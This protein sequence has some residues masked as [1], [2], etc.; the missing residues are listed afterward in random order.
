MRIAIDARY[1]HDQ[2]PGIGRYTYN[3]IGG[4]AQAAEA[5][6]IVVVHNS[7]LPSSRFDVAA[8][9]ELPRVEMAKTDVPLLSPSE[10]WR[11]PLLAR[12]LRLDVWHTPYYVAPYVLPCPL[13]V[14]IHD[15]IS[16]RYPQYLPSLGARL[17]YQATMRL[18][19]QAARRV[20]TVSQASRADLQHFFGLS[21]NKVDV[22]QE[23]AHSSYGPQPAD[24]ISNVLRRL[25]LRQPYALYLGMNKP[26]KNVARLVEAWR[27]ALAYPDISGAQT[28]DC[29]AGVQLVMAGRDDP[30]Y[31]QA[32]MMVEQTGIGDCVRFLGDVAEQDMPA[33]Y[34]GAEV[35]VFPSL[36]EGF[37]L[38]P[39]E[40]MACGAPVIC[41]TTPALLETVGDAAITVDALDAGALAEAL[42]RVLSQPELRQE[43]S[44]RSLA[45]AGRFNWLRTAHE[46]LDV[47]HRAS[48]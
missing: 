24:V 26:H 17:A 44:K 30:R 35:F 13:V 11:L 27:L 41:S 12:R 20:I 40:A 34:S 28:A 9:A 22:V 36:Y 5:D 32:Q 23:A 8:L 43:M 15:A 42:L 10:Q 7:A 19:I 39:L 33:V 31:T 45:Q 16:S 21:V 37:G 2:F 1:V 25:G 48:T 47:Y 46:T 3:L 29:L 6:T 18:A 38:P 14:T 4:L